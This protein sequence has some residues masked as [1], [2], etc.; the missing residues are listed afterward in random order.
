MYK[1]YWRMTMWIL[2][3]FIFGLKNWTST[4]LTFCNMNDTT[5]MMRKKQL[6]VVFGMTPE[7][8]FLEGMRM[9]NFTQRVVEQSIMQKQPA[10][11]ETELKIEVF[12]RYYGKEFT[13]AKI[14]EISRGIREYDDRQKHQA[15]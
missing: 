5:P 7:E 4:P 15:R 3:T 11:S 14:A 1:T 10:L 8:R 12:K 6:A 9:I 2:R 13:A